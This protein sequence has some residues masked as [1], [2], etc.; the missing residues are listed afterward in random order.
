MAAKVFTQAAM[1]TC[2]KV[3]SKKNFVQTHFYIYDNAMHEQ[4]LVIVPC[5]A[6]MIWTV[7]SMVENR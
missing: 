4:Q 1:T 3:Y 5:T 7:L 6:V 2:N